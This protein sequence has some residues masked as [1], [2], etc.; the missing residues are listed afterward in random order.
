MAVTVAYRLTGD[1]S[2]LWMNSVASNGI[3]IPVN[4][5][6][7][8]RHHRLGL[9]LDPFQSIEYVFQCVF[10]AHNLL[11]LMDMLVYLSLSLLDSSV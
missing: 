6:R 2:P 11:I 1:S 10:Y 7:W 3:G 5:Y 8:D 9:L 4:S